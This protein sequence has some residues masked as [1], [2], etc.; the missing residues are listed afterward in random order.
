MGTMVFLICTGDFG[1][2]DMSKFFVSTAIHFEQQLAQELRGFWFEMMDLDGLPTRSPCPEFTVQPGGV[3]FE[4]PD[5][6]G[7]QINFFSKLANRVL[8]RIASFEV[9]YFDQLEKEFKKIDLSKWIN[10]KSV[11]LKIESHKS[12]LNNEK[13]IYESL[14][15]VLASVGY[16]VFEDSIYTLMI[17]FFK[18]RV[19]ISIDTSGEHLHKRGYAE[20]RGEAPLRETLASQMLSFLK[21]NSD[22][23]LQKDLLV[24]P[25]VGSGTLLFEAASM[26]QPNFTRDYSWLK[27]KNTPKIFQSSTWKN[28]FR[29]IKKTKFSA[30]GC[31]I[32]ER[33]ILNLKQNLELFE[34]IFPLVEIDIKTVCMNSK[35]LTI[36]ATDQKKWI[37]TNP[38]YGERLKA[39]NISEVIQDLAESTLQVCGVLVL[40]PLA[41]NFNFSSF[42]LVQQIPFS[43]QGL[44]LRLSLFLKTKFDGL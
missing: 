15:K 42:S 4:G 30:L 17:R 35:D 38:P 44:E 18:D 19:T 1:S 14:H 21:Q 36:Q 3:E 5:H 12:R 13:S 31:D 2:T 9:R 7:Y 29:W 41:W 25:F 32:S 43:N 34:K 8:I 37:V 39:N 33:S 22:Y 10:Q 6:L 16:Q 11:R 24:D 23:D 26:A 20:F 40:H 28:N 27:F